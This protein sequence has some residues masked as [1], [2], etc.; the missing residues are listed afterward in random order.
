[1][2]F[3]WK[4]IKIIFFLFFFN[5]N[6]LKYSEN[7]K[8]ILIRS[9]EKNKKNSKFFKMQKQTRFNEFL[10]NLIDKT[11]KNYCIKIIFQT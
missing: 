5:I 10:Q 6:A 11:C 2:F 9:K 7:T 4:C 3:T 1:V 8:K